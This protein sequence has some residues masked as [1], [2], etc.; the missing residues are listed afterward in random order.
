[1]VSKKLGNTSAICKKYYIHPVLLSLYEENK[2][3]HY[4]KETDKVKQLCDKTEL[5]GVEAILLKILSV[6]N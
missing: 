6:D 1:M 4:F 5:K 3:S 2:L